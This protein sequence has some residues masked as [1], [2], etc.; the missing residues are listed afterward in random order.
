MVPSVPDQRDYTMHAD[1]LVGQKTRGLCESPKKGTY[2]FVLFLRLLF[3]LVH[4][5]HRDCPLCQGLLM[6]LHNVVLHP[7]LESTAKS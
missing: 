4:P 1:Y 6:R 2:P 5:L 3:F 7:L